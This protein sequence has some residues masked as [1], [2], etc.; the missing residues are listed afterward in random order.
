[1]LSIDGVAN[2][3]TLGLE[4]VL[5]QSQQYISVLGSSSRQPDGSALYWTTDSITNCRYL[6]G[7]SMVGK[8]HDLHFVSA[9]G[10]IPLTF[11]D[12]RLSG[13]ESCN[14]T[15]LALS[16][17]GLVVEFETPIEDLASTEADKV[18]N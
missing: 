6:P 7:P 2:P 13:P 12:L 8:Y 5:W 1:M 14:G 4:D 11:I 17:H 9:K 15:K 16:D 18:V 10:D 3:T